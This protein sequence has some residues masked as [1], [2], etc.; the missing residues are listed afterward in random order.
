MNSGIPLSSITILMSSAPDIVAIFM[1]HR[2]WTDSSLHMSKN[3]NDMKYS[4]WSI[5]KMMRGKIKD[6]EHN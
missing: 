4:L 1:P 5:V 3:L 2:D 6:K